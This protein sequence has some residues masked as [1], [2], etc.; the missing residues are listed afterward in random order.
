MTSRPRVHWP[1]GRSARTCQ[2]PSAA[3]VSVT[4]APGTAAAIASSSA[5]ASGG[6]C[7]DQVTRAMGGSGAV[8]RPVHVVLLRQVQVERLVLAVPREPAV[9]RVAAVADGDL[10]QH[11]VETRVD[12]AGHEQA[13]VE[14]REGRQQAARDHDREADLLVEVALDVEQAVAAGGAAGH[15]RRVAVDDGAGYVEQSLPR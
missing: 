8:L 15:G 12:R 7:G 4:V 2:A 3:C 6:G 11:E 14:G 5:A 13:G 10:R 1:S 9:V